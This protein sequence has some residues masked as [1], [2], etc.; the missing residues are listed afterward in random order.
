[1]IPFILGALAAV[2]LSELSKRNKPKMADGGGVGKVT[3]VTKTAKENNGDKL[4]KEIFSVLLKIYKAEGNSGKDLFSFS[5]PKLH[6]LLSEKAFN[7]L[8]RGDSSLGKIQLY[9]GGLGQY[10]ALNIANGDFYK[11]LK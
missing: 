3:E 9:G 7:R 1:M 4:D 5:Q 10:Y 6:K 11:R 8:K 2:G